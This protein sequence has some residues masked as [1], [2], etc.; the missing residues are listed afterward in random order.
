MP[1]SSVLSALLTFGDEG[2]RHGWGPGGG[3]GWL[4]GPIVLLG[5]VA[6]IATVVWFVVSGTRPR[7]R[8]GVDRARDVLAER[9]AR[10]ELTT[11]EYRERLEQLR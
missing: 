5:W 9:Y 10:G 4:W 3:W 7:E 6:V 11:E 2:W 8:S 1:A